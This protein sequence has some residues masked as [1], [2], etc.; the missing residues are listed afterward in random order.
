MA[1]SDLILKVGQII[2]IETDNDS[3][4]QP[5]NSSLLFGEVVS[6]NQLTN[7]YTVTDRVYFDSSTSQKFNISG[8]AYYLTTE[9]KVYLTYPYTPL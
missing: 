7:L 3:G 5:D 1:V 2:L 4:F 8:I 9:D 6:V